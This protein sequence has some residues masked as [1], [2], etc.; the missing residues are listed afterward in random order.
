MNIFRKITQKIFPPPATQRNRCQDC[1]FA[2]RLGGKF[3]CAN[4]N[5][6]FDQVKSDD[7]CYLFKPYDLTKAVEEKAIQN[8]LERCLKSEVASQ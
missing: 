7:F 8:Y 6:P 4:G 2:T 5:I 3:R 1:Y